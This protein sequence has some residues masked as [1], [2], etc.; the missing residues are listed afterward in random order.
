MNFELLIK[1]LSG[2]AGSWPFMIF[3]IGVAIICTVF[4]RF[5]Q[6]RYFFESWKTTLMPER[7]Y[8]S[9]DMTPIQAFINT[10]SSN[11]GNG[12]IA[13]MA[14]A[15]H[16]GGPGATLWVF[17]FGLILM[18]VRF[19]EVYLSTFFS[20]QASSNNTL[21]GPMLYLRRV[22]GG[23]WLS[24]L[25]GAF[26]LLFGLVAGNAIQ[27]NSVRISIQATWGIS[28]IV[29]AVILC[30]FVSYVVFGG[31]HRIVKVSD[32]IVP[33]KVAVFF[34]S[35]FIVLGYHI[36]SIL[37]AFKLIWISAF[38]PA[39]I[40][41]GAFGI[42][43]QQAIRYGMMRSIFATESGLGTSAILFGFSGSKEPMKSGFMAM[44]STFV[45]ALVCSLVGVCIVVSGVWQSGL[46][47]TALTIASFVTVFGNAGGWIVSFLSISF[48][49]GVLVTYAYITRAAWLFL[50]NGRF[51]LGFIFLYVLFAA[52]GALMHVDLVW[53]AADIV[54]AGM[55]MINLYGIMYLL[56]VVA[57]GVR[58]YAHRK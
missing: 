30:A 35:A 58:D 16:H 18:S 51:P 5:V 27:A 22:A 4:F 20:A 44:V 19:A 17:V 28:P 25:Y 32:A 1:Q 40:A 7:T 31:A 8:D 56:P 55:L 29:S 45:S 11:L 10:L 49:I 38:N 57:Q 52:I 9:G 36:H 37:P 50:T 21:G 39:A 24:V 15:I 2:I 13:G 6:F 33:I 26:C 46:D 47:S 3:V 53:S 14:T 54:L 34:I 43:V 48:G 12:S 42:G 23:R 41:G